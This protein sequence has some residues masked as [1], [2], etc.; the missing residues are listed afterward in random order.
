MNPT[1]KRL[2]MKW[3]IHGFK[4]RYPQQVSNEV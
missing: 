3:R 1:K 2:G 4:Q